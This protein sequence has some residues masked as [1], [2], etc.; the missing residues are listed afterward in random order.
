[1]APHSVVT[2]FVFYL[3]VLI[4]VC[5]HVAVMRSLPRTM[6]Y[7][8]I[9]INKALCHARSLMPTPC[10]HVIIASFIFS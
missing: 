10:I 8:L 4:V 2:L 9:F 5:R 1:M 7:T 3:L 6:H